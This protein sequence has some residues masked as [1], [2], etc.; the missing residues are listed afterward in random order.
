MVVTTKLGCQRHDIK[1]QTTLAIHMKKVRIK[2]EPLILFGQCDFTSYY[3]QV[4]YAFLCV[5]NTDKTFF[6]EEKQPKNLFNL[7]AF[8]HIDAVINTYLVIDLYL[9]C[10]FILNCPCF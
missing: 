2:S 8:C 5:D 3:C 6:K 10:L 4:F 1:N 7:L 9:Y